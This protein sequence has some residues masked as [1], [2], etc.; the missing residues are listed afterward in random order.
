[1]QVVPTGRWRKLTIA[2]VAFG[3]LGL[4]VIVLLKSQP[5]E[6]QALTVNYSRT[7][8]NSSGEYAGNV[9]RTFA[10]RRDGSEVTYRTK[11]AP[12]GQ[13]KE[14]KHII[15]VS[16]GLEIGVDGAT[17]SRITKKFQGLEDLKS[18]RTS[19]RDVSGPR[20][21]PYRVMKS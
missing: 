9:Q 21:I 2:G 7:N 1:M 8:Y 19:C 4:C 13:T 6:V 11:V 18:G 12:D 17:E 20:S 15:D 5:L 14:K 16:A 3:C 10:I